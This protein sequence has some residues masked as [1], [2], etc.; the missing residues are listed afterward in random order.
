[1]HSDDG[2]IA[3]RFEPDGARRDHRNYGIVSSRFTQASGRYEGTIDGEP[4]AALYG[5]ME[6]HDARW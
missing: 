1:M 5:V 2:A 6:D 3:L 4:V